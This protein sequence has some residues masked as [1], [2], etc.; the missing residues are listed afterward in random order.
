MHENRE[1][2]N[3][4]LK[5]IRKALIHKTENRFA[6]VDWE[7][8]IHRPLEGSLEESFAKA[9]TKIGGQFVYCENDL[10]F[11]EKLVNLT[12]QFLPR[13]SG[14]PP[15]EGDS[16]AGVNRWTKFLCWE[17]SLTALLDRYE[18]P[19]STQQENFE[20]GLAALTTCEALVARTGSVLVSSRQ[21]S[22]R[23][24]TILPTTHII[25]AYASQLVADIGDGLQAIRN[26]YGDNFPSMIGNITGPSRT[27]DIEKTLVSPAH[28]PRDI[29][30]FL[31]DDSQ[32]SPNP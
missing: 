30:V 4:V 27:A 9:F 32:A 18:Y 20:D 13:K 21:G 24:L 16:A 19:Y 12:E 23:K 8:P 25:L 3:F 14:V 29:F 26:R 7:K 22:G 2:R 11:A 28:G 10:D 31:V 15:V 6:A 1:S 17:H 5:K